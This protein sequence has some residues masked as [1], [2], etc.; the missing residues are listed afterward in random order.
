MIQHEPL[1]G[2][3]F[4]QV[5]PA[6]GKVAG[7]PLI[8][9]NDCCDFI[10]CLMVHSPKPVCAHHVF[11]CID[12]KGYACKASFEEL[13]NKI[14]PVSLHQ[15]GIRHELAVLIDHDHAGG[16]FVL[17]LYT[18]HR[19]GILYRKLDLSC[20]EV[21]I[22]GR[23]L[24]EGISLPSHK[25]LDHMGLAYIRCPGVYHVPILVNDG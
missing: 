23:L 25:A 15:G 16:H 10:P 20:P 24:L 3:C 9:G 4:Y 5:I 1:Q 22:G 8:I 19:P 21:A 2:L 17:H 7:N 13:K 6:A 14:I 11:L 18:L 12:V